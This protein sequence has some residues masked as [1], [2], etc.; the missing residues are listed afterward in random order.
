M[1]LSD[2]M[3]MPREQIRSIVHD[4]ILSREDCFSIFLVFNLILTGLRKRKSSKNN[5]NASPYGIR[6]KENS[7]RQLIREILTF[8][9]L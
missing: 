9:D 3:P 4:K 6:L 8:T 1:S 5:L 7:I 2:A